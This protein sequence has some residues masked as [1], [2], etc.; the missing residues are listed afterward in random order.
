MYKMKKYTLRIGLST[1]KY[2]GCSLYKAAGAEHIPVIQYNQCEHLI[3]SSATEKH[4]L[5]LSSNNIKVLYPLYSFQDYKTNV[6]QYTETMSVKSTMW[7]LSFKRN[8]R[9]FSV[10]YII[11]QWCT[12][13]LI[14]FVATKVEWYEVYVYKQ[15]LMEKTVECSDKK[16]KL[17]WNAFSWFHQVFKST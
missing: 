1:Y 9:T 15:L 10:L 16:T 13:H 17:K 2:Q 5:F 12:T 4:Y 14:V 3:S 6:V 11:I 7:S 8:E